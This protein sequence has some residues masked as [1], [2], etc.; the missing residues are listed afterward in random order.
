MI[1]SGF[2]PVIGALNTSLNLRLVNQNVL[3][4]NIANA[5]TP[6]YKAQAVEFEHA[7][8]D[9]L[10]VAG[11]LQPAETDSKHIVHRAT[12]PVKPEIFD[13]PSG[14][15]SLDGNTVD[16]AAEMAKLAENQLLYDASVEM[17]KRKLGM[18]KYSISEGGGGNR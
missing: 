10:G 6:G 18:L 11:G 8:R 13:D 4:A 12:D 17:L 15:E 9:A 5:D 2:D 3:T 7:L 14:V 16:R 1:D